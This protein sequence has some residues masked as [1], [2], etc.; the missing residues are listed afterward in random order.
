MIVII[1][2]FTVM[3]VG[4]KQHPFASRLALFHHDHHSLLIQPGSLLAV[5]YQAVNK[6]LKVD[7]QLSYEY[8]F[9]W[10]YRYDS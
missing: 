2:L 9:V 3:L 7:S 8:V 1:Y 10:V 4:A 6:M 5:G